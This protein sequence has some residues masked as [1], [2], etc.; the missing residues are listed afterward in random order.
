MLNESSLSKLS[1][2]SQHP[3]KSLLA[4]IDHWQTTVTFQGPLLFIALNDDNVNK[5]LPI[6]LLTV[7]LTF[8]CDAV[9]QTANKGERVHDDTGKFWLLF[10]MENTAICR[11]LQ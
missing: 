1:L 3:F 11:N 9:Q 7:S 8:K 4:I 6:Q 2:A 5:T 10:C